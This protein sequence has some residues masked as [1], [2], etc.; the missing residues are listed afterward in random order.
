MKRIS[1]I[2]FISSVT[3]ILMCISVTILVE[4]TGFEF[5]NGGETFDKVLLFG[6]PLAILLTMFRLGYSI[7]SDFTN[8]I[9]ITLTIVVGVASFF[10]LTI[11]LLLDLC[12]YTNSEALFQSTS[13]PSIEIIE[14]DFGCGAV[15][16]G[17]ASI[18]HWI[19][20]DYP[21]G[22]IHCTRVDTNAI[23]LIEWNRV[24][25]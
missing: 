8:T 14:R 7:N 24:D 23:D 18:S 5:A 9:Q 17:P 6:V 11:F 2:I 1:K 20:E 25:R 15:D 4:N 21:L 10:V 13:D 12:T 22:L 19:V 16:S 3:F